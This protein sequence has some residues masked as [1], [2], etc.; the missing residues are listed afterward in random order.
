MSVWKNKNYYGLLFLSAIYLLYSWFCV[1][2]GGLLYVLGFLYM[3]C[4]GLHQI[5]VKGLNAKPDYVVIVYDILNLLLPFL[6]VLSG[7]FM[8]GI[9]IIY[10][11]VASIYIPTVIRDNSNGAENKQVDYSFK[12]IILLV[13][14]SWLWVPV[15]LLGITDNIYV[16]IFLAFL[17]VFGFSFLKDQLKKRPKGNQTVWKN[18]LIKCL[19][20]LA[21]LVFLYIIFSSNFWVLILL[22]PLL[23]VVSVYIVL[24]CVRKFS[25]F[26]PKTGAAISAFF[27]NR[28]FLWCLCFML[29]LIVLLCFVVPIL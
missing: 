17:L 1:L 7:P 19:F 18:I 13:F 6:L 29:A 22:M 28:S 3:M 2:G 25:Q 12:Y 16:N 8:W 21:L 9:A 5:M 15:A 20:A 24:F 10:Y 4:A 27:K 11:I 23:P 26:F 14:T